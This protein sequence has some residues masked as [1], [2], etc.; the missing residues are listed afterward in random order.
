MSSTYLNQQVSI[1]SKFLF[2][3]LP[4]VS[5]VSLLILSVLMSIYI[6]IQPIHPMLDNGIRAD[7]EI[8]INLIPFLDYNF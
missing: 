7:T 1:L 8:S 4:L 5:I 6:M 3:L 2:V